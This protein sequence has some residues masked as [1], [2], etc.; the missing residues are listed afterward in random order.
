[1][2]IDV[3]L[4][5]PPPGGVNPLVG[6]AETTGGGGT[7]IAII[8]SLSG[9]LLLL[10]VAAL[11]WFIVFK[12]RSEYVE[13][14]ELSEETDAFNENPD[15]MSSTIEPTSFHNAISDEDAEQDEDDIIPSAE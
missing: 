5:N 6:T 13:S 9:L 3:P 2:E 10:I 12:R 15:T 7:T 4:T 14:E 1:V 8:A 11:L